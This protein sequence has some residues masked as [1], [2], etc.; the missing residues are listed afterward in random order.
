MM[1]REY[2][3]TF[4]RRTYRRFSSRPLKVLVLA[5]N[6]DGTTV[7]LRWCTSLANARRSRYGEGPFDEY[8]T[9]H[10]LRVSPVS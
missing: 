2:A 3:V 10:A 7:P 8:V 4:R 1:L 9:F 6:P 5:E